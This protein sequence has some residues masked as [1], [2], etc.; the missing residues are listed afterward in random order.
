MTEKFEPQP[1]IYNIIKEDSMFCGSIAFAK[2]IFM[3]TFLPLLGH[4][5]FK[6]HSQEMVEEYGISRDLFFEY[7]LQEY[8]LVQLHLCKLVP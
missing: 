3:D 5:I 8:H 2:N 4:I 6:D 1:A 7:E